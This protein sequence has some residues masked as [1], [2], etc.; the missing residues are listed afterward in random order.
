ML[1]DQS[2]GRGNVT[3]DPSPTADAPADKSKKSDTSSKDSTA[4]ASA[5]S[6]SGGGA[7]IVR[8][9]QRPHAPPE[10]ISA[11]L[12]RCNPVTY[13]DSEHVPRVRFAAKDCDLTDPR[14]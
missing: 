3:P 11:W 9:W 4:D 2:G 14:P 8:D 1:Y 12:E 6:G 7:A 10:V 5:N 13:E